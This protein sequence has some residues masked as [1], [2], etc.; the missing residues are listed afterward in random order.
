MTR[1]KK[2][3]YTAAGGA[4]TLVL[5]GVSTGTAQA[6]DW[7]W[8]PDWH[9]CPNGY[10]CLYDD[11]GYK[12]RRIEFKDCGAPYENLTNWGFPKRASSW[13]NR[14]K[15]YVT[16]E[17]PNGLQLWRESPNSLVEWVGAENND[18]ALIV[19]VVC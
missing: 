14:T 11:F 16:V 7:P 13:V 3:K 5:L 19:T 12:G 2:V 10:T 4:L 18:Q 8:G 15:H 1:L 6:I 17:D 9:G